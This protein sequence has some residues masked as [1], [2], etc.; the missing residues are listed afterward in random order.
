MELL[1]YESSSDSD[2]DDLPDVILYEMAFIRKRVLGPRLNL[3]DV[4]EDD[5]EKMFRYTTFASIFIEVYLKHLC[6]ALVSSMCN[7]R[8]RFQKEDM[9]NT[10][11]CEQGTKASALEALMIT[12]RRLSYPNRWTDLVPLFGRSEYELSFIF[13]HVNTLLTFNIKR[14]E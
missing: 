14:I 8:L 5:C 10:Y 12:L 3:Q 9:Q 2:E 13:N 4:S 6:H 1:V 7:Y 11:I